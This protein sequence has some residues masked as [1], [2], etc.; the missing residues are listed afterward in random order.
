V[1]EDIPEV[2][3]SV[4][5]DTGS[6]DRE[7]RLWLFVVLRPGAALDDELVT[8]IKRTLRDSISPRH[9]PDEIRAVAAVPRTLS[10]KKLEIPIKKIL[11]GADPERAASRDTLSDPAALDAFAAL[12]GSDGPAGPSAQ[13]PGRMPA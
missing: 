2:A 8:R 11:L 4:V 3:D 13:A 10:G 6:L 12:R 9:V 7:G 5:V 1:V